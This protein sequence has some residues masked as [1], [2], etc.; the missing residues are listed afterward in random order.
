MNLVESMQQLVES[1]KD[2]HGRLQMELQREPSE[3]K[4]AELRGELAAL[5]RMSVQVG[6]IVQAEAA[7]WQVVLAELDLGVGEVVAN[8]GSKEGS[9]GL[10]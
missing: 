2:E 9:D 6:G 8:V 5:R 3:I 7:S 1:I 10:R 4:S